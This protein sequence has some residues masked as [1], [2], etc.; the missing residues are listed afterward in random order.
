MKNRKKKLDERNNTVLD[1]KLDKGRAV[2]SHRFCLL[3]SRNR[4]KRLKEKILYREKSRK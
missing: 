1:G 3:D 4:I 2:K